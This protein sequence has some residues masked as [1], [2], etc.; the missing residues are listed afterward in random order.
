VVIG[1][2]SSSKKDSIADSLDFFVPSDQPDLAARVRRI[3]PEGVD[4]VYEFVG[5]ATFAASMAAVR[6]GGKIV[7][8]GAGSG[9][10]LIDEAELKKR[11]VRIV[12]GPMAQ[13]VQG[14]V[15]KA[16][17]AVFDAYR[18]GV[19]GDFKATIYPLAQAAAAHADIA[20]RR[21]SG[22]MIL[23]P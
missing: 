3:A 5:K 7:T 2:G 8:I 4:V 17:S 1:T 9:A 10:P 21:K 22:P 14:S 12:G 15:V 23:V 19:F 11:N 20:A 6:D 13:F 16:T 18:K